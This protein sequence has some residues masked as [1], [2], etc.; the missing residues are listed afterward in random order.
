MI[1]ELVESDTRLEQLLALHQQDRFVAI[2]T[3]FR[4]R[5]TFYPQVALLQLCW[6]KTAY[7]V[8]PLKISSTEALSH[9]FTNSAVVKLLHS[10]SEDLEVFQHWLGVLPTPL[11]DT[12]R[13][14]ALLGQ[15]FGL[16]YRAMVEVFT[17]DV[18]S[19]AE[20]TSDWLKR[21]LSDRQLHYAALD[22]TYLRSIGQTL[23][24]KCLNDGRLDWLFE[25][26][27][28]LKIGGKGPS[29]KFKS[30]WKLSPKEQGVLQAL[31]D[32]REGEARRLDRPRSWIL[33]DAVMTLLAR[34]APRH[35]AE[36]TQIEGLHDA[37]IRKRG[38]AILSVIENTYSAAP[39]ATVLWEAPAKSR[40]KE[41]VIKLGSVVKTRAGVL[42]VAPE[43]LLANKDVERLVQCYF[44]KKSL[45]SDLLGWRYGAV[46]EALLN[47]LSESTPPLQS[48]Q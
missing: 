33:P 38:I 44:Q 7:L 31:I 20:T 16:G 8:D 37:V 32:W 19:K 36:L 24:D 17:G 12:Q 39:S 43:I 30:A 21:P 1:Y 15:G 48:Q 45:P 46:V 18:I 29:A 4:R 40:E 25:D 9:L 23:H 3:E 13:A 26:T 35:I 6:H 28:A 22:V 2:D 41:W 14:L 42:G 47:T 11:F 5:D 34:K 10:P 27:Q